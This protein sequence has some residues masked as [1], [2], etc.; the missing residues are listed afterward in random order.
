MWRSGTVGSP[1]LVR[2]Q[3][4]SGRGGPREG[5]GEGA[6]GGLRV[7]G[8]GGGTGE[9]GDTMRA[10]RE[11]AVHRGAAR[12]ELATDRHTIGCALRVN[13]E[14]DTFARQMSSLARFELRLL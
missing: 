14:H 8:G 2:R 12:R 1:G 13:G 6:G 5:G 11:P 9:G 7:G 4:D 10:R 3:A